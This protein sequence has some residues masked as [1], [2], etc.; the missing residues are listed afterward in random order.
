ML[1]NYILLLAII[2]PLFVFAQ[3]DSLIQA[4]VGKINNLYVFDGKMYEA[5]EAAIY[6]ADS[7][8]VSSTLASPNNMYHKSHLTDYNP[9]TIWVEGVKGNGEGETITFQF[10]K[11]DIPYL[12]VFEP[13]Y[14]KSGHSWNKNNRV[15]A[16]RLRFLN[17][18]KKLL[19]QTTVDFLRGHLMV[20][21]GTY[22][23]SMAD[24]LYNKK[25][26]KKFKYLE[27]IIEKVDSKGTK[28][29]DT[30][31]SGITFYKK[32]T[33]KVERLVSKEEMDQIK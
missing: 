27:V 7:V 24:L 4:K 1:K 25:G 17:H 32:K 14:M 16:F 28:F 31:V 20:Y 26:L 11:G 3:S 33:N 5:Y 10:K 12:I 15:A 8:E 6:Y 18:K 9:G 23:A 2:A 29:Q 13:G 22:W 30:C 19:V 21:S